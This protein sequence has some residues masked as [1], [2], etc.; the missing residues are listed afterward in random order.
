LK[1]ENNPDCSYYLG[2]SLSSH[3][4]EKIDYFK[5]TICHITVPDS[6]GLDVIQ[7]ARQNSLP[8]MG[9]YHSN[10]VDYMDHYGL[11]W[12]KPALSAFFMHAYN[13]L[14]ALYVP[15]PYIKTKLIQCDK[16]DRITNVQIWGRGIDLERF[17]PANRSKEFRKKLGILPDEVVILFVGRLVVEKRPDIF[18]NVIRRLHQEGHLFKAIVVG[19]GPYEREMKDLPNTLYMGWQSGESLS[20]TYASSDIFLFPSALETFGNVTLEAAA[21]GLPLVVEECCSG[22]LVLDGVNGFAC[23]KDDESS[24][25][26]STLDL[27]MNN[28]RRKLFAIESRRHSLKY[29]MQT[30]MRQMIDNY[31]AITDQ[32]YDTY[33]GDHSIRDMDYKNPNSFRAGTTAR[34]LLL[35]LVEILIVWLVPVTWF[36]YI[37]YANFQNKCSSLRQLIANV[38]GLLC[39]FRRKLHPVHTCPQKEEM[40]LCKVD[41]FPPDMTATRNLSAAPKEEIIFVSKFSGMIVNILLF[42][43]RIQSMFMVKIVDCFECTRLHKDSRYIK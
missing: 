2:F 17:S 7:Y 9:T 11:F 6:V 10:I 39:C 5:P 34:P 23:D 42:V 38:P 13:F 30:I 1:D 24:F 28:R 22:H 19:A 8:L 25:Y 40:F 3:D 12:L 31:T 26:E 32:F 43:I 20:I 33:Q 4:R 29:E 16:I 35:R 27:L 18:A 21:S 36:L 14:Q 15:T 37:S 41:H